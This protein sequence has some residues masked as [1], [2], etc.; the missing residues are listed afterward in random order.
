MLVTYRPRA[1]FRGRVYVPGRGAACGA[2]GAGAAPVR[3]TLPLR[4]DCDVN[5]AYAISNGPGGVINRL[6][7]INI[8]YFLYTL[9]YYRFL[10]TLD[11]QK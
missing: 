8:Y 10:S 5:Y 4:G 9:N 2:R 1:V 7:T 3:L 6:V 11:V